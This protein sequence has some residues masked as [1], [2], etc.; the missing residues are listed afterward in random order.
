[1]AETTETTKPA[2]TGIKAHFPTFLGRKAILIYQSIAGLLILLI[3]AHAV[4]SFA[5]G[6]ALAKAV[7]PL[8]KQGG[9]AIGLGEVIPDLP[10]AEDN[11]API[12]ARASEIYGPVE[13]E[14]CKRLRNNTDEKLWS[15]PWLSDWTPEQDPLAREFMAKEPVQETL[16]LLREAAGKPECLFD[17]KY[18]DG[19]AMLLPHL[20]KARQLTRLVSLQMRLL[21]AD[22]KHSEALTWVPIGMAAARSTER[23]PIVISCLVKIACE[24]IMINVIQ[25]LLS[26][27][28]PTAEEL[29]AI[30]KELRPSGKAVAMGDAMRLE[31]AFGVDIGLQLSRGKN[32]AEL[33]NAM[34]A[35]RAP[36]YT[37]IVGYLGRPVWRRATI[38]YIRHSGRMVE[39]MDMPLCHK[40]WKDSLEQVK[41]MEDGFER[42]KIAD[43]LAKMLLPALS[44]WRESTMSHECEIQAMRI[45]VAMKTYK[46]EKGDWAK[47]QKA[48]VPE[49]LAALPLDPYS[50]KE[51]IV[52]RKDGLLAVYSVGT[53]E[54]DDGGDIVKRSAPPKKAGGAPGKTEWPDVGVKI[55]E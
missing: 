38:N 54:A 36:W 11:A 6:R 13:E 27:Y 5:E 31:R 44:R 22:G 15:F 37:N 53:N 42:N 32:A 18:K 2:Q 12:Y 33:Y 19:F 52:Q 16:K 9:K 24:K 26:K 45:A 48:L 4:W 1:M 41:V 10:R 43:F 40:S 39:I 49:Y 35:K 50:D 17:L 34:W 3:V 46:L 8:Q 47:E 29:K 14:F 21:A 55:K 23:E 20:A 28:E 51:F 30:E 7:A 25:D